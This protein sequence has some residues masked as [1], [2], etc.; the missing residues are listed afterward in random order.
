MLAARDKCFGVIE[1]QQ[2]L[3]LMSWL[4][5]LGVISSMALL[6]S[7]LRFAQKITNN[8]ESVMLFGFGLNRFRYIII[9]ARS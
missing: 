7:R 8:N 9:R 2:G 1:H 3:T 6:T 5:R 4:L